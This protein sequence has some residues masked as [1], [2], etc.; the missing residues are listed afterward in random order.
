MIC[1]VCGNNVPDGTPVCPVCN[2]QLMQAQGGMPQGMPQQGFDGA[3]APQPQGKKTGLIIGIIAAAIVIIGVIALIFLLGGKNNRDGRYVSSYMGMVDIYIDINGNKGKFGM[4]VADEYASFVD[5]EEAN[6]EYEFDAKWSGDTLSM[7][8]EGE[9]L[10]A[11]YDSSKKTLTIT[12]TESLGLG[13]LVFTKQ[14]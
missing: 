8:V 6:Q 12:D 11:K 5:P 3:A 7:T 2:T 13:E 1:P 4:K 14:E 10:D 9:T